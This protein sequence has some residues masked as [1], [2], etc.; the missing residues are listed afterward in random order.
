MQG[1][2]L[3]GQPICVMALG[4]GGRKFCTGKVGLKK[5][6]RL[7]PVISRCPVNRYDPLEKLPRTRVNGFAGEGDQASHWLYLPA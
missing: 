1:S 3:P 2:L 5:R 4:G 7:A 6:E